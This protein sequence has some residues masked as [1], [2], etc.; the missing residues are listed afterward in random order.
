MTETLFDNRR[1][2][3]A[4]CRQI[5]DDLSPLNRF[6]SPGPMMMVVH[7]GSQTCGF[8][9][10]QVCVESIRADPML[11]EICP[12][13][14]GPIVDGVDSPEPTAA[15]EQASSQRTRAFDGRDDA[16]D[17][18][19]SSDDEA[20]EEEEDSSDTEDQAAGEGTDVFEEPEETTETDDDSASSGSRDDDPA[21]ALMNGE[22]YTPQ[23]P[24]DEHDG[25]TSDSD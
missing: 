21:W 9:A 25:N 11:D 12:C 17:G 13:G 10:H 23:T 20:E 7:D 4:I 2:R 3:C 24:R 15:T 18:G 6:S 5:A 22:I 14:A 1:A 8:Y 19:F 16:F